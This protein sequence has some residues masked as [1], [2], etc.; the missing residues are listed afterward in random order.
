MSTGGVSNQIKQRKSLRNTTTIK[1]N[2]NGKKQSST[3]DSRSLKLKKSPPASL[4]S[5]DKEEM[6]KH[7]LWRRPV[8]TLGLFVLEFVELV[9]D[10]LLKCLN[11]RKTVAGLMLLSALITLGFYTEGA[12]LPVLLYLRKK[13]LWSSYWVGLGVASSIGLGTG[14]HTF[15]LY[16]GPF[17]AQVT[18][19]AYE[20][21]SLKFPEP[22]YPED[23][24]CP[25]RTNATFNTA[26]ESTDNVGYTYFFDSFKLYFW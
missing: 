1:N 2:S 22:P 26:N 18:L 8:Q 24:I 23:I 10:Y 11:Y 19:A 14:L 7:V 15:L 25:S 6:G 13:F 17:I 3:Y 12:H 16:L 21:N 9:T 5:F 20:C 4:V